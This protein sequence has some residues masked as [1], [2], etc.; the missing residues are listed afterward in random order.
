MPFLGRTER[1]LFFN[2]GFYETIEGCIYIGIFERG[3][4]VLCGE[5]AFQTAVTW[6][7]LI[8]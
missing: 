1:F 6:A 7:C 4:A 8:G 2:L 3:I 5:Y